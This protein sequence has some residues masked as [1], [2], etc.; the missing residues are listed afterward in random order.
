M[1]LLVISGANKVAQGIIR[2]LHGSGKYEKIVC[3]DVFPNYYYME[4]FL[5]F[6]DTLSEN[7]TKIEEAK[8]S[9]KTDLE[10]AIKGATHVVYV[11]HD[12]Y[13]NVPSKLNLIKHTATIS[14]QAGIKKL[15]A[16]TPIEN[17]HYGEP[18]AVHD[19]IQSE[20]EARLAFPGL[21]ELK[22]DLTFGE[23]SNAVS[24]LFTRL[25]YGKS[26]YFK[27]SSHRVSPIHTLNVAEATQRVLENTTLTNLKY[28]ARGSESLD[29]KTVISTLSGAIGKNANLNSNALENIISP[30]SDNII[31]QTVHHPHYLNLTRFINQYQEPKQTNHHELADLGIKDT[32]KFTE[33]YKQNSV[34]A[35][36]YQITT[37][38]SHYAYCL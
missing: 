25:A 38:L 36:K 5:R 32:I 34:A 35:N 19:A 9:D 23:D 16:V 15:V 6:K 22:T 1:S 21:V 20:N 13:A 27:P 30:L 31:S 24:Q 37:G 2:G 11:T 18:N 8:L 14:R 26:I 17:D 28:V 10:T 33:F 7:K 4:R 3:A 12:Y 29:W